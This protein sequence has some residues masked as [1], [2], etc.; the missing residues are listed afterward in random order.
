MTNEE[1]ILIY[2]QLKILQQRL[3][4]HDDQPVLIRLENGEISD[5]HSLLLTDTYL[6]I[7]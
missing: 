5:Y 7:N 3:L 6:G 2:Q 4:D 1:F